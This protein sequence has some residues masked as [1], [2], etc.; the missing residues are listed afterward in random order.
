MAMNTMEMPQF[1]G[2]KRAEFFRKKA[3][4]QYALDHFQYGGPETDR[5][6]AMAQS[7][8][9][10]QLS[11]HLMTEE[12]RRIYKET[13]KAPQSAEVSVATSASQERHI[14]A[15]DRNTEALLATQ[16][17]S[18]SVAKPGGSKVNSEETL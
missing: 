9:S 17:G 13:G 16:T 8:S 14:N 11:P 12:E 2:E 18:N 15:L 3:A 6:K 4:D 5:Y 1:I 7:V 10:R